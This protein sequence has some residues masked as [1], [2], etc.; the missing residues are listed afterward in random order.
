MFMKKLTY[1]SGAASKTV[2]ETPCNVPDA[3]D[4][5]TKAQYIIPLFPPREGPQYSG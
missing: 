3:I 5:S 4:V 1:S 2:L